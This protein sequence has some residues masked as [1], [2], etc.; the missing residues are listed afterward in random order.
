M[1]LNQDS[2]VSLVP[3]TVFGGGEGSQIFANVPTPSLSGGFSF[4]PGGVSINGS[5]VQ[6]MGGFQFDLPMA[7]VQ[8]F[9]NQA[10]AFSSNNSSLNRGFVGSVIS[11]G[12]SNVANAQK[13]VLDFGRD[14]LKSTERMNVNI[15][16]TQIQVAKRRNSGCFIT[17]AI[18][19][20]D[21]L[22]DDCEVLQVFRKFRDTQMMADESGKAAVNHYYEIAPSI[23]ERIKKRDDCDAIL[24]TLKSRFLEPAFKAIK[25]R[26]Y[27]K[28]RS[29]YI[30][31]V[32]SAKVFSEKD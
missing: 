15:L 24:A 20:L 8:S 11:G 21:G 7:T 13:Q 32:V 27:E 6:S 16:D 19:E 5:T 18:C 28:A 1:N 29:L 3:R 23:L 9:Q 25:R 4:T 30:A 31:L 22:P 10:L 17:T 12:Q 2:F 14:V 26:D